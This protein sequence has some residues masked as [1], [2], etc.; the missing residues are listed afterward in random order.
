MRCA[1]RCEV[2]RAERTGELISSSQRILSSLQE[3][4]VIF[5]SRGKYHLRSKRRMLPSLQEENII[6][7]SSEEYQIRF[8]KGISSLQEEKGIILAGG[9]ELNLAGEGFLAE[10]S[11]IARESS[12]NFGGLEGTSLTTL[13]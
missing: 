1:L 10:N 12:H 6:F 13:D 11:T 3:K 9:E 7:A 2:R 5:A 4:D 8:Q